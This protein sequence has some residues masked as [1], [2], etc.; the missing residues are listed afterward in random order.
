[1]VVFVGLALLECALLLEQ[2]PC[3]VGVKSLLGSIFSL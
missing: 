2:P 3:W 1:M